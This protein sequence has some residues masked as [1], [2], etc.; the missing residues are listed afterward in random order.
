M[1]TD[2]LKTLL[3]ST[4]VLYTKIHGFHF[5]VEGN[6][7][8][9]YHEFFGTF[10]EEVYGTIDRIGE[11]IRILGSYSPNSLSRMIELSVI[12]EQTKIPKTT[13]MFTELLEDSNKMTEL[14]KQIFDVATS[15]RE[16]SIA[17][18][19]ADLQDLYSKKA[20]MLRSILKPTRA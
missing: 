4:F 9:Q 14:V 6:D 5:N 17:N 13:L 19:M 3:G 2:D 16:Q 10:Y 12:P 1:L 18:Y 11:Y 20:W 8:P 7:F 15:A